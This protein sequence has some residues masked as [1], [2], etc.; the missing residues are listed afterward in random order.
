MDAA[1]AGVGLGCIG[2]EQPGRLR[3]RVRDGVGSLCRSAYHAQIRV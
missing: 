1:G 2:R 3:L